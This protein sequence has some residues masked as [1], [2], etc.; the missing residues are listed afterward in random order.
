MI[1]TDTLLEFMN[2]SY[3]NLIVY[4]LTLFI[5]CV[6]LKIHICVSTP[7]SQS[8]RRHG[9]VVVAVIEFAFFCNSPSRYFQHQKSKSFFHRKSGIFTIWHWKNTGLFKIQHFLLK[10]S[11]KLC[12]NN[13]SRARFLSF[14]ST[15][16]DNETHFQLILSSVGNK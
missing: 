11:Q 7:H 10:L 9:S 8:C 3:L 13:E 16:T 4:K 15:D 12:K 2:K 1:L 5:L 14:V 6:A